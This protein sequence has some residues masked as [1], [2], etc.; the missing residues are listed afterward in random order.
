MARSTLRTRDTFVGDYDYGARNN[1]DNDDDDLAFIRSQSPYAY[2]DDDDDDDY[3][4]GDIIPE[5]SR[6]SNGIYHDGNYYQPTHTSNDYDV[7]E[8]QEVRQPFYD[9]TTNKEE[10]YWKDPNPRGRNDEDDETPRDRILPPFTGETTNKTTY[11]PHIPVKEQ[12]KASET[13]EK[14]KAPFYGETSHRVNYTPKNSQKPPKHRPKTQL[15][16]S[17]NHASDNQTINQATYDAKQGEGP[18]RY[19]AKDNLGVGGE[20]FSKTTHGDEYVKHNVQNRPQRRKQSPSNLPQGILDSLTTSR[21]VYTPKKGAKEC[22]AAKLIAAQKSHKL[23]PKFR[24]GHF[25]LRIPK[26]Y[27]NVQQIIDA[28]SFTAITKQANEDTK[29][30]KPKADILEIN[31]ES[32]LPK[33][34]NKQRF[35]VDPEDL[36]DSHST[37]Y[38]PPPKIQSP[39]T[40][41]LNDSQTIFD[42]NHRFSEAAEYAVPQ[43]LNNTNRQKRV[44]TPLGFPIAK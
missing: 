7:Y 23:N 25:F 17:K 24:N 22:P 12:K 5:S 42:Q 32:N 8:I 27:K 34:K 18:I 16:T 15:G 13:P 33:K 43:K 26:N 41:A 1:Q 11:L 21:E 37:I 2:N 3:P 29:V 39:R 30:L 44:I 14:T 38:T 19:I 36:Y 28:N 40:L 6:N 9:S 10:Y 31:H 20:F 4:V 35:V